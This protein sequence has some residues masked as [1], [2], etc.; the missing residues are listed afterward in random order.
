MMMVEGKWKN[1]FINKLV[2]LLSRRETR[3]VCGVK[4]ARSNLWQ[5]S[6]ARMHG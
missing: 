5:L 6:E 1:N 2:L 4:R 3:F